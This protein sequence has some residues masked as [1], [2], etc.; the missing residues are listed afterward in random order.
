[1]PDKDEFTWNTMVAAYA[2]S[3]RLTDA[4]KLFDESP[5]KGSIT[6]SG[7]IAGYC[8]YGCEVEAFKLFSEMHMEGQRP[9]QYT[10]GSVLRLCSMTS[11][12][13]RGEQIHGYALKTGNDG[14]VFVAT[15]L[16]DMYAKCMCIIEAE[17]LFEKVADAKNHAT[18]TAMLTGYSHN[19]DSFQ[20][21]DFFRHMRA[22]GVEINQF[23][24]PSILTAC[25]AVLAND[26]GL[27]VHGCIVK[28][29]FGSNIFVQSAL[30]DMYAKCRDLKSAKKKLESMEIDD[31]ISWNS[32]IVG[33]VNQGLKG[34]ALYTFQRMHAKNMKIDEYTLPSVLNSLASTKDVRNAKSVHCLILKSGFGRYQVV[35]NA[36]VDVYSKQGNLDSAL[37]IF[38]H[39]EG[40][41]VVSWTSL[42]VG[43]SHNGSYEE[44]LKL[45]C[46]MHVTGSIQLDQLIV[47]NIMSSCAEL[48]IMEFGQQLHAILVKSGLESSLSVDNS[49]VTMY[50]KC[51]AILDANRVFDSMQNRNVITYTAL[52]VGYAQ[53]GKGL[54]SL[55]LY[56]Q[57]ISA[58]IAPDYITFIGL[59]FACSHTGSLEKGRSYF[60]SMDNIHGIKP[61]AE[62]YACM[63]D[64][65]G[66]SGNLSEAKQLLDQMD[67]EPD[68]TVWKSLLGACR[69]H[70]E[71]EMG[72]MAAKE[73]FELEPK[74]SM[75]YVMLS[76][77]YSAAGRWEDAAKIRKLMKCRGISKEPGSSWTQAN[78]KTHTFVSEDRSHPMMARIYSKIDEVIA[79]I[80]EAGYVPDMSF[81][82]HD[83]ERE[84]KE[85]GLAYHS[86]K[87]ALAFGLLVVPSGAVIRIYKNLRVCGDC[88]TAFKYIS[89]LY[90]RHIVLRDS[91]CF[92]H[93]VDGKCSCG[94]YW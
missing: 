66:R 22:Q 61:G 73:L 33:F 28:S 31:A 7:L 52:I 25:A 62:H 35:N 57:M 27:Q 8:R 18:W 5:V 85:L 70:K 38:N 59:L 11:S 43:Y 14:N 20:A 86:E 79:L 6:W 67:V 83:M 74:N 58:G 69:M 94:D 9:T 48:A 45:F 29:G 91:N 84:G 12:L 10:M 64:L 75:P 60:N 37:T 36:L 68:A 16:V 92:H 2:N 71:L 34:E 3:G 41:D 4:R 82:L 90:D 72:E 21:M 63:I 19:R 13:Q 89:S 80:K 30:V 23:T 50:A 26:F 42:V 55:L 53:N 1:M 51:G 39:M 24:F 47:A 40:K 78:G 88:H 87:L 44:S 77:L 15:G 32:L 49:L 93:F 65:L 76:N 54:Y 81:V 56:D 46:A 17:S